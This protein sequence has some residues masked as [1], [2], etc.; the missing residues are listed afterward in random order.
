MQSEYEHKADLY[1]A[2]ASIHSFVNDPFTSYQPEMLFQVSRF[3]INSLGLSDTIPS[4]ISKT[5]TLYTLAKQA[6]QLGAYKL[7]RN[8]FD[9]LSKLQIPERRVDEVE[10]DMLLVQAKPV[11]D[12]PEHLPVCYRCGT[13]NPLLNPFTNRF[14]KG[15]VCTN[16]GH[17]FVRS[18]INFDILPLVEFVPEPSIS[19]EEAIDLIRQPSRGSRSQKRESKWRDE[20]HGNGINVLSLNNT[21][22]MDQSMFGEQDSSDS[23][24][25][26]LNATLEKQVYD[27]IFLFLGTLLLYIGGF[28]KFH[29]LHI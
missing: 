5:S 14:A 28:H 6:M 17:P 23:F 21:E 16:C 29:D 11:R 15:D 4:G 27:F 13:T 19:D 25:H 24:S 2:Y 10:L 8:A 20:S 12:E 9:R 26:C 1:Y 22:D 18:F 7:A 3:I